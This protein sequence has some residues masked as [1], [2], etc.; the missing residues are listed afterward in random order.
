MSLSTVVPIPYST[1][2]APPAQAIAPSITPYS[3]VCPTVSMAMAAIGMATN[4]T[5]RPAASAR[6]PLAASSSM[7][8]APTPV[9]A[10]GVSPVSGE[11]PASSA[12]SFTRCS[13]PRTRK[14]AWP[15]LWRNGSPPLKGDRRQTC[16]SMISLI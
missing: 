15:L 7:Y 1:E 10:S 13:R 11:A 14:R 8:S 16:G 5:M 9:V 2:N 6:P 3:A 4:V 12:A